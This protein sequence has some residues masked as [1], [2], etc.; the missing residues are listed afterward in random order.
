MIFLLVHEHELLFAGAVMLESPVGVGTG[1]G[2][3][4]GAESWASLWLA[5]GAA[6]ASG[7]GAAATSEEAGAGGVEGA[8]ED[9]AGGVAVVDGAWVEGASVFDD[10]AD[11]AGVDDDGL[12]CDEPPA[13]LGMVPFSMY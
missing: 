1:A 7:D 12:D 5:L 3:S 2:A 10:D 4:A 11:E 13:L 8:E 6:G 9:G